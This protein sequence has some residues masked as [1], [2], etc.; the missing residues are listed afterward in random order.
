M[1]KKMEEGI[2]RLHAIQQKNLLGGGQ[3]HIDRQHSRGK[4]TARER[5][6]YFLDPGS[7][8]ELGSSVNATSVRIDGRTTD[9]PC[10]GAV[11]GTGKV[12]GRMIAVYASDFTVLGGSLGC[13]H[14]TKF[15]KLIDMAASWQI[16]MV[17]LLDSSGGRLGYTDAPMAGIDWWFA[18]ESRYSGLIPQINVL[19]GPCIA[20]QAYCPV[21]C[22]FLLMSRETAHLW[23]GGPRMTQAATSEHI[24]ENVGGADYHMEYTG[25]CDVVGADDRETLQKAKALLSYLPSNFREQPP[26]VQPTDTI[27]RDIRQLETMVPDDYETGYDMHAVI[28]LL[29]DDG[30]YFEIKDNYARQLITCFCRFN[31]HVAGLVANNPGEP[32]GMLEIDAC[33]KYYRF[34]QVLDA[35]HIP[36]VTLTDTPPVVPGE[37]Q[38]SKG[39][40]RHAGR[41]L[42]TYATATIPKISIILRE[43]YG[44]AGS[45]MMGG[46]KGMGG[47]LSYAWPIAR[48]AVEASKLDYRTVY[49]KGVEADA[50]EG[51]LNRSREKVTV[52]EAA[53]SWSAQM[54][55]EVIEPRDT[56]RKI[57]E[58]LEITKHK[59]VSLPKRAKLHGT[60]PT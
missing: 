37:A 13:Q 55:D 20:G 18:L 43:A 23:L 49:G 50:Y 56:R 51:Y 22:D 48:F 9:A 60:G 38:E 30:I 27:F 32:G 41:L 53:R 36:L 52:F 17:W 15:I 19:M 1:G 5:I 14:A 39:L 21:L 35:Y 44:D 34:L 26:F 2:Q 42:D 46:V 40:L 47:D 59:H 24:G 16:P 28:R 25:T 11:I 31:G 57:I 54:V 6:E 45:M 29:V 8:S 4:L 10:D 33:D 3:K 7:F 12:E 58:A